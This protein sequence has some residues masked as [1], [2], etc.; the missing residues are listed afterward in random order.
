MLKKTLVALTCIAV[1]T[2]AL[3]KEVTIPTA[4]GEVTLDA[5]PTKIAVFDTGSLDTL[6][7]LGVKVDGVADVGKLLPYL[8]PTLAQAKNV[9]TIFEPNLEALNELKPDLIIVGTRTAKKFD[10]VSAIAKTVDL[11]D[12]GDKLV[13]SGIQ[14]IESFGKLFNKQAEADKLKAEIETLFKQTKDAVKGKGNGLII[15]VNGGKISAFGKGYRLSFIHED[16]GVPMADPSINVSGH[17][18]PISFEFIEK[19]NPDWLFVLDRI[20]AIGQEG[21]SAKEVLDN[22]LIHH[23][24][25]W[26]N[27]NIVYLSSA[28]YLAPGG[29]EQ[30]KMDL[31]N[32]KAAFEKK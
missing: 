24:K 17:G 22:E 23:T 15:L 11:T 18:Q 1:A 10:D 32:I 26:K 2:S 28:S 31:N 7:A 25:A 21:K 4:R 9:G 29:A 14:R 19:T 16:L 6:Q 20:S 12:S 30:L 8:K 5:P 13:E 3:A 27:G